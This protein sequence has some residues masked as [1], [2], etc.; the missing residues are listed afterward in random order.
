MAI[1]VKAD[2]VARSKK[3]AIKRPPNVAIILQ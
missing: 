2:A 3:M 1:H